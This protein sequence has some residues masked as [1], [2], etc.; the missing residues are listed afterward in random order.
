MARLGYLYKGDI[1]GL[2]NRLK[3]LCDMAKSTLEKKRKVVQKYNDEGLYPYTRRYINT[4]DTFFSTIGVNG[5]NEM[6]R[7]FT[8][9]EYD[10]TDMRGQQMAKDILDY[11]NELILGYQEET[12]ILYN[13]EATP[14][15]G[16][17]YRLAKADKYRYGEKT[18]TYIE[19]DKHGRVEVDCADNI[20]YIECPLCR[21]ESDG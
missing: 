14:A 9:D 4:F 13:L 7:N 15:E 6:I 18:K 10:I 19:C 5:I 1:E 17:T 3:E 12:G 8:N 2:K 21:K 16:A 11:I 20:E